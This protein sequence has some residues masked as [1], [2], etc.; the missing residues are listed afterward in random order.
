ML[1]FVTYIMKNLI[2]I[3]I[4]KEINFF[5]FIICQEQISYLSQHTIILYAIPPFGHVTLLT[6]MKQILLFLLQIP[7]LNNQNNLSNQEFSQQIP[8]MHYFI[9]KKMLYLRTHPQIGWPQGRSPV[10][11]FLLLSQFLRV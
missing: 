7:Q 10:Q 1:K 6:Y 5:L 2:I 8:F 3:T 11:F 9:L 4:D